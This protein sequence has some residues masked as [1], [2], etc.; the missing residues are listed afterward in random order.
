MNSREQEIVA[1]NKRTLWYCIIIFT[2]LMLMIISGILL[3][4]S[5]EQKYN[6]NIVA[7]MVAYPR[8]IPLLLLLGAL[9]IVL[10]ALTV[11]IGILTFGKSILQG[12]DK[13]AE[14]RYQKKKAIV[15]ARGDVMKP[16]HRFYKEEKRFLT[17][18]VERGFIPPEYDFSGHNKE[19]AERKKEQ[20]DKEEAI[21]RFPS[22]C[23]F[24][25]LHP[26]FESIVTDKGMSLEKLTDDFR[27]Y[28]SGTKGLYYSKETI[29]SFIS[30]LACSKTMILQGMSGTGKTSLPVAFGEFL[31]SRTEVIP[32]QPTWKE[33][34]DILGYY[35]E[36]TGRYSESQLLK[37][38]Y[39][40]GGTDAPRIIVLDEANI[41]RIEYYF[42]EFLSL[43]E[44]PSLEKRRII[45]A[46]SG[47][48]KDP[49]RMVGG[50]IWLPNNVYFVL[51]ANNDD[52]TFAFSD[53][54]Y[55]RASVIDLDNRAAPFEATPRI[56][57]R[58]NMT[59]L[60]KLFDE[61]CK[62]YALTSRDRRR[63]AKLDDYLH[64]AFQISFGNRIFQ[65]IKRYVPVFAACGCDPDYALDEILAR[66]VL[67]K[68]GACNPVIVRSRAGDLLNLLDSLFGEE[69]APMCKQAV[70]RYAENG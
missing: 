9:F 60:D 47:M 48:E 15:E 14:A 13:L 42:A 35:N 6:G 23:Q 25:R 26:D 38:I 3:I 5:I 33:R 69:G 34:S 59:D 58:I 2:T 39:S 57:D 61:A 7:L 68:L 12:I 16:R 32:V 22:L 31:A 51:T 28:A 54:V 8:F 40:A 21:E 11:Y 29:A 27:L 50:Q 66:K 46:N 55:D 65:Q 10:L 43:L 20:A 37:A 19:V 49:R 53:K 67:R 70:R 24:D 44:L 17:A 36:F 45:V 30:G 64:G 52:S 56:G 4:R 63:L 1:S 41:A 18:N 62:R